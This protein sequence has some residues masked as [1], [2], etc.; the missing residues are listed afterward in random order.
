M[1]NV[2]RLQVDHFPHLCEQESNINFEVLELY[3]EKLREPKEQSYGSVTKRQKKLTCTRFGV[4]E[5]R[6]RVC[7]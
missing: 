2:N 7:L 3:S 6:G 4:T 1:T 5:F